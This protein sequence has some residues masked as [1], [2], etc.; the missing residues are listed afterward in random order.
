MAILDDALRLFGRRFGLIAAIVLTVWLPAHIAMETAVRA[1]H[2]TTNPWAQIQLAGILGAVIDPLVAAALIHMTYAA[3]QGYAYS[4]RAA[5]SAGTACW[6]RVFVTRL[7]TGVLLLC[8][9]V[10]LIV[11]GAV[12]ALH[13][14]LID[15]VVVLEGTDGGDARRRS[16]ELTRGRRRRILAVG[17]GTYVGILVC[18]F[19]I[20]IPMALIPALGLPYDVLIDCAGSFANAFLTIVWVLFFI[21][22]K[23]VPPVDMDMDVDVDTDTD[24]GLSHPG[25]V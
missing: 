10:L 5:M 20:G 18:L 25:P 24:P 1:L 4:Y 3:K 9:F 13:W 11:P 16:S 6:L 23:G 19:I 22:A 17:L 21:E 14:A 12:L 8:G 15:P 2:W 7:G